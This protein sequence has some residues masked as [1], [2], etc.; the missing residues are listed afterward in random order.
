MLSG[1]QKFQGIK[2]VDVVRATDYRISCKSE[3]GKLRTAVV[4]LPTYL[5]WG[6]PIN[7]REAENHNNKPDRYVAVIEHT[8]L[9]M[10][11]RKANVD[12]VLINPGADKP[13]GVYTRDIGITIGDKLIQANLVALPRQAEEKT[14]EGGI[15]PPKEA[16][17][18][19]GNVILEGSKNL[20]LVGVGR[21]TNDDAIKWLQEIVGTEFEVKAIRLNSDILHLDCIFSPI[22][23]KS[24]HAG[25]AGLVYPNGFEDKRDLEFLVSIYGRLF[26]IGQDE[27]CK[28]GANTLALDPKTRIVNPNCTQVISFLKGIGQNVVPV[29]LD[30][31]VK[32]EGYARCSVMPLER[33]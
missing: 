6:T 22:E 16:E 26:E 9:I 17:L 12:V 25:G 31:I 23:V 14:V 33:E 27:C 8:K 13:E 29:R 18:E 32:G 28:L 30:E 5:D 3:N 19:G 20:M 15:K 4:S 7:I 11:L 2:L 24:N 1:L 10:E 21:R